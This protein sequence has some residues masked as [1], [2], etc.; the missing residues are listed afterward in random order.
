MAPHDTKVGIIIRNDLLDW[1][2]LNVTAFLSTGIA[3]SAPESIGEEYE[4]GAG[5]SY[6]PLIIQ[7]RR[8][9]NPCRS[10]NI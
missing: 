1:Q 2:K 4:D 3:S 5:R 8:Y 10:K 9:S 6:L 7:Y